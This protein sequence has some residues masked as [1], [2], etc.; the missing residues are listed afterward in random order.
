MSFKQ[1][2]PRMFV[3]GAGFA[4]VATA[5]PLT[6]LFVRTA[7]CQIL[8]NGT[9]C[10]GR[11]PRLLLHVGGCI[12]NPVDLSLNEIRALAPDEHVA[13]HHSRA[14]G[15]HAALLL[16]KDVVAEFARFG[17]TDAGGQKMWMQ[18]SIV[19]QV[20]DMNVVQEESR[21]GYQPSM[22]A[23]PDSFRA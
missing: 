20:L 8:P 7:R 18:F 15:K 11:L 12:N 21:I 10:G 5:H 22:T 19:H 3:L 9:S 16:E 1:R 17:D 6:A 2:A 4:D 14:A 13:L 23:P